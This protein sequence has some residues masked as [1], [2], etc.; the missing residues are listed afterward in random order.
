MSDDAKQRKPRTLHVRRGVDG[1]HDGLPGSRSRG[2]AAGGA[3]RRVLSAGQYVDG[4]L[5]GDRVVLARAITLIES[6]APAHQDL[7]QEVLTALLPRRCASVR[8]GIT[9]VPG[10]GKST[11]IEDLGTRLRARGHKV[12]VTAVDPSS[13]VTGGSVLGDK[14]RMEKLAADPGAFI[15]PSPAGGTLGGVARKTRETIVLF[16]AAGYDVVLVETVGVGQSEVMVRSMADFFLLVLIAGAGD[17]LQGIKRGV[18]EL[19]DAVVINKADGTGVRAAQRTRAEFERVLHYLRPATEGWTTRA[20]TASALAGH[21]VDEIWAMIGEFLTKARAGGAFD[22]R[23]ADQERAWVR[24][25]VEEGLRDR[26][27]AHPQVAAARQELED[28]VARGE[29]PATAAARRLLDLF[30]Q[31]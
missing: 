7:A 20:L 10:A 9:G 5:A 24:A 31:G 14:T 18:V 1:G 22:R 11:L 13:T 15:R 16:E 28:Q 6:N 17:E 2:E 25:L 4:V 8:V 23:R 21:G 12:A 3:R 30:G 19:A 27:R 26:F 29:L